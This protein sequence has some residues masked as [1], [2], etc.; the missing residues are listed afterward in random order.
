MSNYEEVQ[1]LKSA[2]DFFQ[3]G[4]G[5][6]LLLPRQVLAVRNQLYLISGNGFPH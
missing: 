5:V 1:S 3:A 4:M 2:Y 6:H